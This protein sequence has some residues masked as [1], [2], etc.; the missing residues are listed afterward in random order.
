MLSYT[1]FILLKTLTKKY[2]K[3]MR[4][5]YTMYLNIKHPSV[6]LPL[7]RPRETNRK[8]V[9]VQVFSNQLITNIQGSISLNKPK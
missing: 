6:R 5:F 4:C 9:T 7:V 1:R 8:H 2:L 3:E